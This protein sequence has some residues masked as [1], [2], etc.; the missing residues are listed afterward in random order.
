M[1]LNPVREHIEILKFVKQKQVEL[2]EMEAASRGA[3]E[4]VLR[5]DETGE[6]DGQVVVTWKHVKSRRLNQ[7]L[8]KEKLPEVYALY[9]DYSE[10][11]RF[12]VF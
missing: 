5:G 6:L 11:R 8:L 7:R 4:E 12:E 10:S 1:N 2:K 3:I 9:S